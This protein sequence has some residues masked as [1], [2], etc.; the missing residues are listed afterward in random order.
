MRTLLPM[1]TA[2]NWLSDN[3]LQTERVDTANA[4][5]TSG[6]LMSAWFDSDPSLVFRTVIGKAPV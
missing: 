4:D 6:T 1:R 5:A 3:N 2:L